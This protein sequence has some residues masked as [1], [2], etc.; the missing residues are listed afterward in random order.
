MPGS[1]QRR[2]RLFIECTR[3]LAGDRLAAEAAAG[4]PIG[5]GLGME[6]LVSKIMPLFARER[7]LIRWVALR[8]AFTNTYIHTV[9]PESR[10]VP[11]YP[12]VETTMGVGHVSAP[13]MAEQIIDVAPEWAPRLTPEQ[14]NG[15][16]QLFAAVQVRVFDYDR[17]SQMDMDD[18]NRD[19]KCYLNDQMALEFIAWNAVAL[20]RLGIAQQV[21]TAPEPD[22][23][24]T[25]GWYT[26][27]LWG[28]AER[29]WDGSDW[30][31]RCRVAGHGEVVSELRPVPAGDRRPDPR[32]RAQAGD[33]R[34]NI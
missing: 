3:R 10:V 22:A 2:S 21:M 7:S 23:L 19:R 6:G 32:V 14:R 26:D 4:V 8:G 25:P 9:D 5:D 24:E 18:V 1:L 16:M 12:V 30:T 17:Y 28:K 29:Y 33:R 15:A 11:F 13:D 34:E 20:L 31:G 27:P